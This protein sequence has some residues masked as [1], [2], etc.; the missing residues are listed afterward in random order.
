MNIRA[1]M[2]SNGISKNTWYFHEAWVAFGFYAIG[3]AVFKFFQSVIHLKPL[4]RF[5]LAM[6]NLVVTVL[7]YNLNSPYEGFVVIMKNANHGSSILFVLSAIFGSLFVCLVSTLIPR[8]R[9]LASAGRNTLILVFTSGIF[10]LFINPIL[11]RNLDNLGSPFLVTTTSLLFALL[12]I[13]LS[14]PV[15]WFLNRTVP[16]LVGKPLQEGPWL[17]NLNICF[18]SKIR[19]LGSNRA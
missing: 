16:Q 19:R 6:V 12:S 9:V 18:S 13:V 3:F 11:V 4:V 15:V 7:T 17:S 1:T 8:N 5:E 10:H 14:M 2:T